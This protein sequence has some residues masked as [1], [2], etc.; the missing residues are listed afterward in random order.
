MNEAQ[1]AHAAANRKVAL[2][3]GGFLI[4]VFFGLQMT[5]PGLRITFRSPLSASSPG[6]VYFWLGH[7]LLLFPA[8][9]LLG[10][11]FGPL[12]GPRLVRL[13]G[14]IN[15]LSRRELVLGLLAL[16][17][18]AVAVA[19]LGRS[20]FLY[21]FPF[22]DDEYAAQYGGHIMASGHAKTLLTL[23]EPALPSH[24]LYLKNSYV[25]TGDWPGGQA[26]WAIGELT[27]LGPFVWALLAAIPVGTLAVL[28]RR[29]LDAGW[30]GVAALVFLCSPMALML[31]MTS[32]AHLASRA[33]LAV[34]LAG[35]WFAEQRRSLPLWTLT[36]LAFGL[37][38]LCRPLE[39]IFYSVPLLVWAVV[40]TVRQTPGY[41]RAPLGL[42]LGGLLPILLML[43]H[44]YAVT[45]DPLIPPRLSSPSVDDLA[46]V[47]LW[48]RFGANMGYNT[49]MLAIWFLGPLGIILFA[50]G[51]MT[52]S[53]TK[54][55]GLGVATDL[56]LAL[57]HTNM[58]LHAV[59]PI[60]YS[61]CAVPLTI[62]AVHGLANLLRGAKRH[63]FDP[64][65]IASA[66]TVALTLGL[67]IFNLTHALALRE[68]ASI[69]SAI[70]GWID[71]HVHAPDG[72]K[73]VVLA[74]QFG[75]TWFHIPGMPQ[76]GTWVFEWRRPLLD[77][78]DDVLIL[79]DGP[80]IEELLRPKFSDR[81]FYRILVL[82]QAPHVVLVP[83]DGAP[84]VPW[85]Q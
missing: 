38:F 55:L 40:Q 66:V 52:D 42:M 50:A 22:T 37:G 51:V 59:G 46:P 24:G 18:L 80:G 54:L 16:L 3:V 62:I 63:L 69:Q 8:S 11:A 75:A 26:V 5:A 47:A 49:F 2:V 30:G 83:L 25:A 53:F 82:A 39:T 72:P 84:P 41:S 14:A 44:A 19:R 56:S 58:G 29:R 74:P 73:A 60:H 79:H 81:R 85:I 9:C 61:E 71:R 67:G 35:Y 17:L 68:Q 13:R 12:L 45:G 20:T 7:A 76:I 34:A 6:E 33:M 78:S 15:S 21:D 27:R 36:G 23:P 32:H 48:Y 77:L 4:L 1:A 65:P 70:Y 31:S 43:A 10:Y 57:F 64:L 28:M